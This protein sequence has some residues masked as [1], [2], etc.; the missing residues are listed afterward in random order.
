L[1]IEGDNIIK[2]CEDLS[3]NSMDETML[4]LF[5]ELDCKE[6][7]KITKTEFFNG[8]QN[9]LKINHTTS[10]ESIKNIIKN[11]KK[12]LSN[13][14]YFKKFY[15]WCFKYLKCGTQK[16]FSRDQ[17]IDIRSLLFS[18][19]FDY[20]NSWV[21]FVKTKIKNDIPFDTWKQVFN[22]FINFLVL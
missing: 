13:E 6:Q 18:Q 22:F 4:I 16:N 2:F 14:E 21:D 20:I 8:F 5:H 17:A 9:S 19:K 15:E 3:I 12:K 10:L 11:L 1:V 7:Y